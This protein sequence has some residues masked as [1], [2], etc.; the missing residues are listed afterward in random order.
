[1]VEQQTIEK[2]NELLK[3]ER[4]AIQVYD[5][6][7]KLQQDTQVA[8][9]L[10]TFESDHKKHAEM[11]SERIRELGGDPE[12]TTGFP[13][14]M[15]DIMSVINSIRGPHQLLEQVYDGEDKGIHAYEERLNQLDRDSQV[16][17]RQIMNEDHEHLKWFKVRMEKEK[18]EKH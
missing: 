16:I 7:K 3:G 17:I 5:R 13:G 10:N 12:V 9:M 8:N 6:T 4:M 1:M 18:S 15:A 14:M 2:L 11:L